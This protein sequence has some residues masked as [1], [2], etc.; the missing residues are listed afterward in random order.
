MEYALTLAS[1]LE[2]DTSHSVNGLII[3]VWYRFLRKQAE[4]TYFHLML[5]FLFKYT[6][7][8]INH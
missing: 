7:K 2:N 4:V 6:T 5:F 8:H 3:L 1:Q